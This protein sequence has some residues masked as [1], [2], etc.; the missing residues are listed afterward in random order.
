MICSM[1]L[2]KPFTNETDFAHKVLAPRVC[3][4]LAT[5]GRC[6]F[7]YNARTIVHVGVPLKEWECGVK[8]CI[9]IMINNVLMLCTHCLLLAG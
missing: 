3:C 2:A 9:L 6:V 4:P 8:N 5:T 1:K 7:L